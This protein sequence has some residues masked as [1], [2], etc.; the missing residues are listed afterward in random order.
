MSLEETA[1]NLANRLTQEE[2]KKLD[3]K[4]IKDLEKNIN[5]SIYN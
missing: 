4:Q 3:K 1:I 2:D 5:N